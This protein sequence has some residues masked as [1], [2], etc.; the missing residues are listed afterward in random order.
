MT[1]LLVVL[2]VVVIVGID[3]MRLWMRRRKLGE[4]AAT[5]QVRPF[6][7]VAVPRGLFIDRTHTWVRVTESGEM[8]VGIDELLAQAMDGADR[9]DLPEAG[10]ELKRGEAM[11]T[12]WRRGRKLTV[13]SPI[14]GT[15]VASNRGLARLRNVLASDPYGSGWLLAAWPLEHREALKE[16]SIGEAARRWLEREVS[17]FVD[18]LSARAGQGA[19]GV[20]LADGAWPATGSALA[21]DEKGWEEFQQ[22]FA[23]LGH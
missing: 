22:T 3:V 1:A 9:I 15:V 12:L 5:Q 19:M 14:D 16:L 2:T 13:P 11:A 20:A 7:P 17:K 6:A 18:F 8:R 21:L 23:P 4:A 10:S